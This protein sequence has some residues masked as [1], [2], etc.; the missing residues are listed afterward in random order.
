MPTTHTVSIMN[1]LMRISYTFQC[2]CTILQR[3][4]LCQ[5]LEKTK[6]YYDMVIYGFNYAA[7]LSWT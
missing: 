2:L 1:I 4:Q 6:Y 5:L 7:C 3:E